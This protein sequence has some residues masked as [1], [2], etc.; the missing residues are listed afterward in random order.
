MKDNRDP[1]FVRVNGPELHGEDAA[2]VA[3]LRL[4]VSR[5][6]VERRDAQSDSWRGYESRRVHR[7]AERRRRFPGPPE[8]LFDGAVLRV[9]GRRNYGAQDARR[10]VAD[11]RREAA[12]NV[13]ENVRAAANGS[14]G[15]APRRDFRE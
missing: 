9:G 12:Q 10:R 1:S 5:Q 2:G 7:A 15:I 14:A 11:E 8:G 13:D 3:E 4:T 6:D